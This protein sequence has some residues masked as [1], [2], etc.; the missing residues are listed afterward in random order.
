MVAFLRDERGAAA[1]QVILFLPILILLV[2]GF[3]EVWKVIHVQQ[4][5]NDAAYQG[6]RVLAMGPNN[7]HPLSQPEALYVE[8][9]AENLVRCYVSRSPFVDRRVREDPESDLLRVTVETSDKH[10]GS[11]VQ[12]QVSLRWT[13]G[14][15]LGGHQWAF[16]MNMVGDLTAEAAGVVLCERPGDDYVPGG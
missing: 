8:Q 5:L 4:V 11:G 2:L 9:I 10:C 1:L 7:P 16:F 6:A 13:V 14:E 12:V 3:Y 15:G